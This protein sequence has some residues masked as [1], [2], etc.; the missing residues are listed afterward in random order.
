MKIE[1]LLKSLFLSAV[2]LF[3]S[4]LIEETFPLD[5]SLAPYFQYDI[6]SH[7]LTIQIDPARHLLRAEDR[8]EVHWR[9][10]WTNNLSFLLHPSLRVT[11]VLDAKNGQS[12]P[13]GEVSHS[14]SARRIEVQ[15]PRSSGSSSIAI[16][17][18]GTLY[19][20]VVKEKALQFVRGDQTSGLIAT[21]PPGRL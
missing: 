10:R 20:P 6:Q 18:E 12:L 15:L 2:L 14:E 11:R 9:G 7:S 17:Y 8:L 1:R 4:G 13:W 5:A 16:S 21:R 19:D 3:A